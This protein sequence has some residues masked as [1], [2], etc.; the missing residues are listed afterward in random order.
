M[1]EQD[2]QQLGIEPTTNLAAIKKAYALKLKTTRPDDDA[3]AYQALRG[4]YERVQQWLKWQQQQQPQPEPQPPTP[5]DEQALPVMTPTPVAEA[6]TPAAQA[7][8]PVVPPAPAEPPSPEHPL[9]AAPLAAPA[10]AQPDS[11]AASLPEPA[12]H[13]QPDQLIQALEQRWRSAGTLALHEAWGLA[14]REIDQQPLSRHA[15]FSLAFA[16]WALAQPAL[17]NDFLRTLNSHFGWLRDFRSG[18]LLGPALVQA[19]EERLRPPAVDPAVR[20][21]AEPLLRLNAARRTGL[22]WL[23]LQWWLFLL[24]PLLAR[25]QSVLGPIWMNTLGLDLEAR[26]WLQAGVKRGLRW[27][28]GV[29]TLIYGAVALLLSPTSVDALIHVAIWLGATAGLFLIG[30]A[31]GRLLGVQLTPINPAA[32]R[33][34][35]LLP[36]WTRE[37][38]GLALGL[39]WLLFAAWLTGVD[40]QPFAAAVRQWL[41]FVPT[42]IVD[43]ATWGFALAGVSMARPRNGLSCCVVAALL[44]LAGFLWAR[45]L[46]GELPPAGGALLAAAWLLAAAAVHEA[47]WGRTAPAFVQ[48]LLRPVLNTLVLA[49]RWSYTTALAPLAVATAYAALVDGHMRPASLLV[50]WVLGILA[51]G[52]LQTRADALGEQQLP[53]LPESTDEP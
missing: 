17:P 30:L 36:A 27:R 42:R 9:P 7:E 21:L 28:I 32:E 13:L 1:W 38:G 24:Q 11:P 51:V 34:A 43:Y 3:E 35:H 45:M 18:R 37:V 40:G 22:G 16:Q 31:G 6:T 44:P 33:W 19:L 20:A 15:E 29:A 25:S 48:W 10:D 46:D 41:P 26:Q 8:P 23:K 49:D 39:V 52:W 14:Q 2:W 53:P 50:C 5:P 4:A 12:P 47:R